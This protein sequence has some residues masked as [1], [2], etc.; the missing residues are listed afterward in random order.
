MVHSLFNLAFDTGLPFPEYLGQN[1]PMARMMGQFLSATQMVDANSS[2]QLVSNYDWES[3]GET[4]IVDVSAFSRFDELGISLISAQVNTA[5]AVLT[6]AL[7]H[8][9]PLLRFEL[10]AQARATNGIGDAVQALKSEEHSR[11]SITSD[12]PNRPPPSI[13][14]TSTTKLRKVFL[15]RH[16][17]HNL[18]D[19]VAAKILAATASRLSPTDVLLIQDLVVPKSNENS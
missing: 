7:A 12:I 18:P 15:L 8:A 19:H 2:R 6:I 1:M 3:L 13:D 4:T 9:F 11:F 16:F 14:E 17:L 5:S 10:Q